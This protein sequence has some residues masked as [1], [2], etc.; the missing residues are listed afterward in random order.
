MKSTA[1]SSGAL[2]SGSTTTLMTGKG[3]LNSLQLIGDGTNAATVTVYDE[4]SATG[5]VLAVLSLPA[6]GVCTS[7]V[8]VNALRADIGLTVVVGGTG[9]NAYV[10]YNA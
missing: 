7:I 6:T 3:T 2:A 10:G 5:K 4:L 8:F 9:G 1:V